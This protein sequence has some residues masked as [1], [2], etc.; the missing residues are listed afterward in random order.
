MDFHEI[1]SNSPQWA[2]RHEGNIN[3][4]QPHLPKMVM[5]YYDISHPIK[6]NS[7]KPSYYGQILMDLHKSFNI[8][9]QQGNKHEVN[10]NLI[11]PHLP[12]VVM[13]YCDHSHPINTNTP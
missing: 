2:K 1:F 3:L 13:T 10:L 4:T 5:T 12:R 9:S 6:T 8:D 11:P 7:Y